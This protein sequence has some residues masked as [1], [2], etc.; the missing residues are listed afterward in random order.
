MTATDIL[1]RYWE[2][3]LPVNIDKLIERNNIEIKPLS[4]DL[5]C[6]YQGIATY[7]YQSDRKTIYIDPDLKTTNVM[8]M[9]LDFI[10]KVKQKVKYLIF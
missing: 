6:H 4:K 8:R 7:D 3:L 10:F 5:C 9:S 2:L 1:E